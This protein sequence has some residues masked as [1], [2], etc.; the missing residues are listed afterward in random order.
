MFVMVPRHKPLVTWAETGHSVPAVNVAL[1]K[2]VEE[3]VAE[4]YPV[5]AM[6]VKGNRA[7]AR[8]VATVLDPKNPNVPTTIVFEIGGDKIPKL[9]HVYTIEVVRDANGETAL[10]ICYDKDGDELFRV[11]RKKKPFNPNDV[12]HVLQPEPPG[13]QVRGVFFKFVI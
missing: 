12:T 13:L 11:D 5:L 10:T 9:I 3:E 4:K 7:S 6:R 1:G 2:L 8:V